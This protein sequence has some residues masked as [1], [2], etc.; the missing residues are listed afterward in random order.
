MPLRAKE[1]TAMRQDAVS[2]FNSAIA[3]AHAEEAIKRCCSS[4]PHH[5][6]AGQSLFDLTRYQNVYVI[7]AG[8]ASGHM[9]RAIEDLLLLHIREGLVI[10]KYGHKIPLKKIRI[11]EAGHPVPDETGRKAAQ[12]LIKIAKKA[13]K[14]DLILCLISGGGSALLPLPAQ[15]ICLTDKQKTIETLL[16]CGASIDEMNIL[17]KHMS[18]IKGGRLAQIVHPATLITLIVS[19]VPG[20]HLDVIASGPTVGDPSTFQDCMEIIARYQLDDKLPSSV[21][22]LFQAGFYGKIEETPKP[23]NPIFAKTVNLIVGSNADALTAAKQTAESLGY[24]TMILSSTIQGNTRD[25]AIFHA[26]IAREICR[27][28]NPL[29][30]PACILSGGETTVKLTGCGL[31]GRNQEFALAAAIEI[32][33]H[34]NIVILCA[35]TDGTDGPTDAAGAIVDSGTVRRAVMSGFDPEFFLKNNDSYHFFKNTGGLFITGP[36]GTNVMDLRVVLV[37]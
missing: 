4:P 21:M 16:A 28:S 15:G 8:K 14:H 6:Q 17:R 24:H 10:T 31:G 26:A 27:S 19:D 25:A 22:G 9:A 32:K 18:L 3:A 2:I 29:P 7:G 5:F 37:G 30:P 1:P 36:T 23:G 12:E 34:E 35:G 33:N 13:G 11:L 20:D